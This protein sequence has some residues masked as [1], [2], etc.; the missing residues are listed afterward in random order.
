[1]KTLA[2]TVLLLLVGCT[3]TPTR[4]PEKPLQTGDAVEPPPGCVDLRARGGAC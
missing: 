3:H 1:M 2:L 4:E